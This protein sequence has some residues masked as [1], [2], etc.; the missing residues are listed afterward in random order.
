MSLIIPYRPHEILRLERVCP[1]PPECVILRLKRFFLRGYSDMMITLA[2]LFS[3]VVSGQATEVKS[4]DFTPWLQDIKRWEPAIKKF[5]TLDQQQ[6]DPKDAILF[7]GSSSIRLWDTI[8]KDM[9]PYPVIQR[10]YGGAKFSDVAYYARRIILPHEFRALV[11]FV[12]NDVSGSD[13]DKEPKEVAA[14]L[15][16]IV[17]IVRERHPEVPIFCLDVRPTISRWKVWPEI[18][19]VNRALREVC[20]SDPHTHFVGT[21][22]AHLDQDG[23]PNEALLREDKLHLS[24]AGYDLW[25]KQIKQAL[26]DVLD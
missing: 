25:A 23:R 8:A 24:R 1:S 21:S 17:D 7:V 4:V 9:K 14:C 13:Q 10:G 22:P 15:Q 19:A 2:L 18:Q 11:M 16:H 12:A 26:A 20:D 3:A 5:E 6:T